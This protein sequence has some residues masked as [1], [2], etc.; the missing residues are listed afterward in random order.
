MLISLKFNLERK[1]FIYRSGYEVREQPIAPLFENAHYVC[2]IKI[3]KT[4]R[5]IKHNSTNKP[6]YSWNN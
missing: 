2:S 1:N 6:T 3:K 4:R 5:Y